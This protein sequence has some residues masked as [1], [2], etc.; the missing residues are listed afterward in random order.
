MQSEQRRKL[1]AFALPTLLIGAWIALFVGYALHQP[2]IENST[3][4]GREGQL[5]VEAESATDA[6][7]RSEFEFYFGRTTR[8]YDACRRVIRCDR[9]MRSFPDPWKICLQFFVSLERKFPQLVP[10]LQKCVSAQSCEEQDFA[11]CLKKLTARM[12]LSPVE[13]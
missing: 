6:S 10:E 7:P 12:G 13:L 9:K 8:E 11:G 3:D 2:K 4:T 5:A 1:A